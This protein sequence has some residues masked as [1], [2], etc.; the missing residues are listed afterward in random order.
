MRRYAIV[1]KARDSDVFGILVGTLGVGTLL[2]DARVTVWSLMFL[3]DFQPTSSLS[4]I[5]Y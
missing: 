3:L 1:Q 5:A 4:C 2:R